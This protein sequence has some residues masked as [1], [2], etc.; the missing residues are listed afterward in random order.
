MDRPARKDFRPKAESDPSTSSMDLPYHQQRP[1][2]WNPLYDARNTDA[3]G[4]A[5][6]EP[7]LASSTP[8]GRWCSPKRRQTGQESI[9]EETVLLRWVELL[10]DDYGSVEREKIMGRFHRARMALRPRQ[11]K[12][13]AP[14]FFKALIRYES[15]RNPSKLSLSD[16]CETLDFCKKMELCFK[17]VFA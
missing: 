6:M 11:S 3:T 2:G 14:S 17:F 5:S 1:V 10:S 12:P 8:T 16:S 15:L 13:L 7:S 9:P 4:P